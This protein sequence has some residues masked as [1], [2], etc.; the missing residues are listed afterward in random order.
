MKL[1]KRPGFKQKFRSLLENLLAL[2]LG[3]IPVKLR[4]RPG[5]EGVIQVS[6]LIYYEE[7][8]QMLQSIISS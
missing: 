1:R 3:E 4:K 6:E 8:M 7:I 5:F 2:W